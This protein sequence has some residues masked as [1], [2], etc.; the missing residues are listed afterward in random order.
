M[1]FISDYVE[2]KKDN[3]VSQE[4]ISKF[5]EIIFSKISPNMKT[6]PTSPDVISLVEK[7]AKIIK[8]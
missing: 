6:I 7:V 8:K 4:D 1:K 5:E 3:D 2:Y